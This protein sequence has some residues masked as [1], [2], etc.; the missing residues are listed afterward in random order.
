MKFNIGQ[1]NRLGNRKN[2]QDRFLTVEKNG[3]ILLIMADGMGGEEG[4]ELAAEILVNTL[5]SEFNHV[6]PH[7]T[8]PKNFIEHSLRKAHLNIINKGQEH[9][10]PIT[11]ATTA[12]VCLIQ[13][14]EAI[15]G[16]IGDSRLYLFRDGLPIFRTRDHSLVEAL[17]QQGSISRAEQETHPQRNQLTQCVGSMFREPDLELG[18]ATMLKEGDTL[19]LCSDGL[20]SAIEDAQIGLTLTTENMENAAQYLAEQAEKNSYPNS[21]NI[22]VLLFQLTH[23]EETDLQQQEEK[24]S[25]K[26]KTG[27]NSETLR[28]AIEQIENIFKQYQGELHLGTEGELPNQQD[29]LANNNDNTTPDKKVL[30]I[31]PSVGK[32]PL[33]NEEPSSTPG[34]SEVSTTEQTGT[35]N[36]NAGLDYL[37][38]ALTQVNKTLKDYKKDKS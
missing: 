9:E 24:K 36:N 5:Q 31:K 8:A 30:A 21:D 33:I 2:N 26:N 6:A 22:S 29:T 32:E 7:I 10:P 37:R 28:T 4:G 16:H 19:L 13:N 14:G 34:D 38:N 15:W 18:K 27:E 1:A 25:A 3:S 17:Y 23:L 20:W 12:V 11:P 35:N